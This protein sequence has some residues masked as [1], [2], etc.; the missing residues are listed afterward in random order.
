MF[1]RPFPVIKRDPRYVKDVVVMKNDEAVNHPSHYNMGSI[2]AID[3]IEDWDLGFSL[4]NAIKYIVR[5]RHK[6]TPIQDLR[7]AIWYIEYRIKQLETSNKENDNAEES[8][9]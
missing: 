3:A 7:K 4:G 8:R 5:H 9:H 6:G 2:E 1:V